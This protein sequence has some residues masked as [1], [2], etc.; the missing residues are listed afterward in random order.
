MSGAA[1]ASVRNPATS[2]HGSAL[3]HWAPAR[4]P[5]P[6]ACIY[7][8]SIMSADSALVLAALSLSVHPLDD[9]LQ[10]AELCPGRLL[11]GVL[12]YS[13]PHHMR[14]PLHGS[15]GRLM[16]WGNQ[17]PHLKQPEQ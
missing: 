13:P 16:V 6:K 5:M 2:L 9:F 12:R 1:R 4:S 3:T 17:T 11:L 14:P 7:Q 15:V 8:V 10:T